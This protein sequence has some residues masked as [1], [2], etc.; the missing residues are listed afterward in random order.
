M[1]RIEQNRKAFVYGKED[2]V[3]A[4]QAAESCPDFREDCEAEC[5]NDDPVSC[6]NCRYRRWTCESFDC[7]KGTCR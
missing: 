7:M 2:P 1:W 3:R 6:Y 5:V 4:R